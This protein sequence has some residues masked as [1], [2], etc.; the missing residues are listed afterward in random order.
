MKSKGFVICL[1][2]GHCIIDTSESI[3]SGIMHDKRNYL[4]KCQRCGLY[5]MH[6]GAISG[7]TN[8]FLSERKALSIKRE[9]ETFTE[10]LRNMGAE[11]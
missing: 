3:V 6:D 7:L 8:R 5:V 9:F 2:S 10:Q 11:E 4:C 1:L